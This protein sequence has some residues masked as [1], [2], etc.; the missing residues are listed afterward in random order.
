MYF[1]R[2]QTQIP[3]TIKVPVPQEAFRLVPVRVACDIVRIPLC[4]AAPLGKV[5]WA[6][7]QTAHFLTG[8]FVIVLEIAFLVLV[9]LAAP[10]SPWTGFVLSDTSSC[11]NPRPGIRDEVTVRGNLWRDAPCTYHHHRYRKS[12]ASSGGM[13]L[14]KRGMG[15]SEGS[16]SE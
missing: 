3:A 9:V 7:C 4:I 5:L 11:K 13:R 1:G 14:R 12:T 2:H 6:R 15:H 8:S 10:F 16:Q